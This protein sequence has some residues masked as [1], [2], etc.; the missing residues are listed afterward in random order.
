M[1]HIIGHQRG[2]TDIGAIPGIP[3][4]A[5]SAKALCERGG[6][7][8]DEST[9]TCIPKGSVKTPSG[10]IVR[11]ELPQPEP[12]VPPVKP[13]APQEIT[14]EGGKVTGVTLPSGESFLGLTPG[15]IADLA[16]GGTIPGGTSQRI[17]QQIARGEALAGQAGQI[18]PS[19][20][21]PSAGL[22]PGVD[23]GD[24]ASQAAVGSIP[25]ALNLA[26]QAGIGA[27]VVGGAIKGA[28]VG[29]AGA[30]ATGGLSIAAGAAL[31]AAAG[32][33]V[34]ITRGMISETKGQRIDNTNAQQRV[35]DEGKQTLMDWV[36][37]SKSDPANRQFY[38]TQFNIQLQLIQDSHVQ[39]LTDTNADV[40]KFENAIPNLAEFNSFYSVGGERDALV[41]EMQFALQTPSG[42]EWEMLQLA[43]RRTT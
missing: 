31:G 25:S 16:P 5:Q 39:M 11:L 3:K 8:W 23:L 21:I 28:T 37:L 41:Q 17:A 7:T 2:G 10:E 38:L 15:D 26:A 34:G 43:Q 35:L 4:E 13:F 36:T 22:I 1:A 32:L 9:Q 24:A 14:G 19:P 42:V 18:Q 27:L 12:V 29:A 20:T 6:G 40:G 33:L 30:P